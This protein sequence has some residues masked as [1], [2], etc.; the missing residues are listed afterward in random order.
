MMHRS[1]KTFG[2]G[3]LRAGEMNKTEKAYS[4]L[5]E[6]RR[7][8]G[9]IQWFRFECVTLKLADNTRYNPDFIVMLDNGEIEFHEVKGSLA[10]I[11]DDARVKIKVA[12]SIFPFRFVLVAPKAKKNGGGWE[13]KEI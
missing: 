3:R 9:Q 8:V 12:A 1:T 13:V 10:F 4:E 6:R 7:L 5:L 11:Q 2:L